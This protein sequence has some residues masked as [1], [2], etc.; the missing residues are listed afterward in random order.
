[1]S[2]TAQIMHIVLPSGDPVWVNVRP[3]ADGSPAG[4]VE[5][6]GLRDRA[7]D[8]IE[9]GQLPGFVEAVRGVVASVNEALEKCRPD[10]VTVEFS[11][12]ITARSGVVLSVLTDAGGS[13]QIKVSASWRGGNVAP[14]SRD[15]GDHDA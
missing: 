9:A 13:A 14:A 15:G 10:E 12:E 7:R 8:L 4:R 2:P 6:V 11:I 3:A 1:M 5:D